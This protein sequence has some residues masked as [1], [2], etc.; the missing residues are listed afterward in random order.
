[1][2]AARPSPRA[3]S[4]S[5]PPTAKPAG[6]SS[7]PEPSRPAPPPASAP[8]PS[9][10]QL[11]GGAPAASRVLIN[12]ARRHS[13]CGRLVGGSAVRGWGGVPQSWLFRAQ[14]PARVRAPAGDA[15][16]QNWLCERAGGRPG[17]EGAHGAP[18]ASACRRCCCSPALRTR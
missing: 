14:R 11:G 13:A 5:P 8:A 15:K 9:Q 16:P 4:R 10:S 7:P 2:A 1:M 3:R 18:C 6:T 17:A 12:P